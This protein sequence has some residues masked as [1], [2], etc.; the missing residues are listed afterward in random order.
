C[1]AVCLFASVATGTPARATQQTFNLADFG[2]AGDGVTDD[3]PAL[4]AALDAVIAAGGGTLLVPAGR[5]VIATPVVAVPNVGG[6]SVEI[7]GVESTTPVP[8]P[9]AGGDQLSLGLNLQSE[10]Q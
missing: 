2:A 7:R 4:Q 8:P 3:G 1:L 10:F 6:V 9:T 5:F